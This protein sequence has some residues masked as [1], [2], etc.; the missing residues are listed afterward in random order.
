MSMRTRYSKF[1]PI[2]CKGTSGQIYE[3]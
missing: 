1:V 3:I 2:G